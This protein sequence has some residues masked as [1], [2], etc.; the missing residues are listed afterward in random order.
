MAATNKF[1]EGFPELREK[2][3]YLTGESYAGVYIPYLAKEIVEQNEKGDHEHINL[4]GTLIGNGVTSWLYDSGPAAMKMAF[5]HG[6]ISYDLHKKI[7]ASGCKFY[8][9]PKPG[10]EPDPQECGLLGLAVM[11]N[12]I[13][14]DRYDVYRPSR[15]YFNIKAKENEKTQ[16]R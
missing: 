7:Q 11:K 8:N 13:D 2:E 10:E 3:I 16:P 6:L 1:F 14:L 15:E 9:I 5:H 4:K 12:F